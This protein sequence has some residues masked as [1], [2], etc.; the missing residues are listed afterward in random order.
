MWMLNR[1]QRYEIIKEIISNADPEIIKQ[2]IISSD[3]KD[4]SIDINVEYR[5]KELLSY[6]DEMNKCWNENYIDMTDRQYIKV[7]K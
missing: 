1:K 2:M 6:L 3:I 7:L 5:R 4:D